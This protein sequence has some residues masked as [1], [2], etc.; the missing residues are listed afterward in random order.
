M[1]DALKPK[2]GKSQ[3]EMFDYVA[4]VSNDVQPIRP[5]DPTG[6]NDVVKNIYVPQVV[7]PVLYEKMKAEDA[8]ALLRKEATAI[9]AKN[10]K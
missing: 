2:L 7:S 6:A 1:R 3:T 9:L 5:P 10:K 8:V 4:R